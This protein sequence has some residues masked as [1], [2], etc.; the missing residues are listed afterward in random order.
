MLSNSRVANWPPGAVWFLQTGFM[1]GSKRTVGNS[2]IESHSATT[3]HLRWLAC[4]RSGD[5]RRHRR[6][7]TLFRA[8]AR[9]RTEIVETFT[10]VTTEPNDLV[11]E[12]HHRMAVVLPRSEEKRWLTG[13]TDDIQEL[14]R[15]CPDDRM[16]T[17]PVSAAVNNPANDSPE[18]VEPLG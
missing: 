8:G 13:S 9:T 1:S 10:I 6:G 18:V 4:G 2:P 12:L 15:P 16:Q 7:W 11:G 17:Y 14:L 3:S 5:H